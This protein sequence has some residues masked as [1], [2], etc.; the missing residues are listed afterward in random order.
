[1]S[2]VNQL[3]VLWAEGGLISGL[4]PCSSSS[5]S[6]LRGWWFSLSSLITGALMVVTGA[7]TFG[8]LLLLLLFSLISSKDTFTS[9]SGAHIEWVICS[10]VASE[11]PSCN[12]VWSFYGKRGNSAKTGEIL[13][14]IA[15]TDGD[16]GP[17]Q[18]VTK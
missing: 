15:K 11:K 3:R 1:M 17:G 14:Q 12:M 5:T 9:D 4:T 10:N 16:P 6:W 13:T 8:W 7:V 18:E 2:A